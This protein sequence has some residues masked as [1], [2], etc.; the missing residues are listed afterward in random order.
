MHSTNADLGL[1]HS[2][3]AMPLLP[4]PEYFQEEPK[5]RQS[6]RGG[7]GFAGLPQASGLRD[8]H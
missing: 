7:V 6:T 2:L 3:L 1:K 4:K 5:G 8:S